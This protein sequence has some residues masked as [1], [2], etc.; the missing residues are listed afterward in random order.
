MFIIIIEYI[1]KKLYMY[2]FLYI[3]IYSTYIYIYK[4]IYIYCF[5]HMD[6]FVF[7]VVHAH[8]S[9]EMKTNVQCI[10]VSILQ[11]RAEAKS[12]ILEDVAD[13]DH[14]SGIGDAWI[15]AIIHLTVRL[16][17]KIC[18]KCM[19]ARNWIVQIC[20]SIMSQTMGTSS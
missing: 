17:M 20:L 8:E 2:S 4:Y 15:L 16:G 10:M 13:I 19:I 7:A 1:T 12:S 5:S 6:N 18:L 11:A 9:R 14:G 3:Y